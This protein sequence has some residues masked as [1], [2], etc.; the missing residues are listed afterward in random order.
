MSEPKAW[1]NEGLFLGI[2]IGTSGCRATLINDAGDIVANTQ[3]PLPVSRSPCPHCREQSPPDWWTA[4]TRVIG[5]ITASVDGDID[6]IAVDGTSATLLLT[7]PAGDP[8]GPALMYDDARATQ[9]AQRIAASAPADSAASG[10]TSALAKL[11]HLIAYTR[12]PPGTR[13]LH[14]ADW[15]VGRLLGRFDF[16]DENNVL[17]LGY[18]VIHRTWPD[19]VTT[20][21]SSQV[22]LPT[23]TPVGTVLGPVQA[24]VAERVGLSPETL[25]ISG[26]TDSNAAALAAGARHPGEA[27]TSLGTTLVVKVVAEHPVTSAQLGVYSHRIGDLWLAGGASNSGGAVLRH[28]FNDAQLVEL[29]RAIDPDSDTGLDYYPLLQPGER[30]PLS[31][32]T[33]AP[34]LNP[35]PDDDRR[36]LQGLLEGMARIEAAGYRELAKLGAPYPTIVFSSG[37]GA[38]NAAWQRIRER[39]LGV[40]VCQAPQLQAAYGSAL[41]ARDAVS[42][43]LS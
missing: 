29:S 11:L 31:D 24:S 1:A 25:V 15:I 39:H 4:T 32:P 42:K 33:L 3:T 6:A 22:D 27:V 30:F 19:W 13:A 16:S 26:M 12:P 10:P 23:V 40:P 14:Q 21:L 18:D 34:R 41:I 20:L 2:D 7:D 35:R 17:K 8:L 5:H 9:E 37:G 43:R 28:F 38:S 36:F